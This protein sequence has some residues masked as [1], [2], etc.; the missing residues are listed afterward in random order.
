LFKVKEKKGGRTG[1]AGRWQ[2]KWPAELVESKGTQVGQGKRDDNPS[3]LGRNS[4]EEIRE[5]AQR[6]WGKTGFKG[7]SK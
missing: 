3:S 4:Q 1:C 7:K 6:T 5:Q 2:K